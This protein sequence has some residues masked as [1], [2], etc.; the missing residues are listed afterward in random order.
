MQRTLF[1]MHKTPA[2]LSYV[3]RD[4]IYLLNVISTLGKICRVLHSES[5]LVPRLA[6]NKYE[7]LRGK[8]EERRG[9]GKG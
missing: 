3:L 9:G 4:V 6:Q 2:C 1:K 5:K 8:R 7:C